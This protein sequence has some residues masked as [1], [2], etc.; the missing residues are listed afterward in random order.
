M[1][2]QAPDIEIQQTGIDMKCV[3]SVAAVREHLKTCVSKALEDKTP[4]SKQVRNFQLVGGG[5]KEV[6]DPQNWTEKAKQTYLQRNDFVIRLI[7]SE[8]ERT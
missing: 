8:V 7:N 5:R 6:F 3:A 4:S 1:K 2:K